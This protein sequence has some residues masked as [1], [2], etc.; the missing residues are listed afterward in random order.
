MASTEVQK[1]NREIEELSRNLESAK[2]RLNV[3]QRSCFHKWGPIRYD[4]IVVEAHTLPGDKPGTHGVD[5]QGPVY[6]S[7]K[8]T[9][10]WTRQ[11]EICDLV[12]ITDK[13][14]ERKVV[15][16]RF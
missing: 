6:V 3:I 16:P 15:K 4:P 5:W 7:R 8:E 11:C 2:E 10:R 1:L 9:P 13:T 14:E 12:Q